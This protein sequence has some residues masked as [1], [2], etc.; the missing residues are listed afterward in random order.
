MR[1]DEVSRFELIFTIDQTVRSAD[2]IKALKAGAMACVGPD[3]KGP[4]DNPPPKVRIDGVVED[5]IAYT[6]RYMII[7]REVSP[8]KA[9]NTIIASVMTHLQEAGIKLAHPKR[10]VTYNELKGSLPR[11]IAEQLSAE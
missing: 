4:L 10:D 3:K 5:G 1:P 2:A 9:R 7:P 6:I 11:Q 8:S